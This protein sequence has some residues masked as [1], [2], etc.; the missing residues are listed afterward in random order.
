MIETLKISPNTDSLD[1]VQKC[2]GLDTNIHGTDSVNRGLHIQ[3][4]HNGQRQTFRKAN[5]IG[6][7]FC[8]SPELYA[9]V[10]SLSENFPEIG[11]DNH[12]SGADLVDWLSEQWPYWQAALKKAEGKL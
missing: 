9:C 5:E 8:A 12:V 7:L 11:T 6:K 1:I 3:I 2:I 10:K 4:R